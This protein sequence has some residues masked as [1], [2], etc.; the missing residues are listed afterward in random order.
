VRVALVHG[1]TQTARSWAPIGA[2]LE[3]AGH[4]VVTPDVAG[5]GSAAGIRA[6]LVTDARRL[7]DAIGPAVWVG[8][9]LGGRTCLHL[10]LE[11]RALVQALVLVSTTAGIDDAGERAARRAADGALAATVES[12]GV[13]RFI[14]QWLSGP[15]W[16]TLPRAAAGVEARL[17]NTAE[18]LAASLRLAGTGTQAPL[19]E[20][21]AEITVPTLV[22]TGTRDA[23]FSAIGDRLAEGIGVA[24]ARVTFPTGHAVPW[25]Q[26]QAFAAAVLDW[27]AAIP[28]PA[29]RPPASEP[30]AIQ[31]PARR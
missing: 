22:V 15:M 24:A 3:A 2:L 14:E 21:L 18:G 6:D 9:S 23:R 26:P 29:S 19:W 1:F 31:G 20:R 11:R 12:D 30:A 17:A 28:A 13:E 4:E 5:H 16:A 10:A 8:Y 7:A 27:L 25:E